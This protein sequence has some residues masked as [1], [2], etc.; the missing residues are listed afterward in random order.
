MHPYYINN[1][2]TNPNKVVFWW[3][4]KCGCIFVRKL[5]HY[6]LHSNEET[7]DI[8][9]NNL[10]DYNHILF[11]RNPYKRVVSGYI[12]CYATTHQQVVIFNNDLS[13]KDTINELI[14]N[15]FKN[16]DKLHFDYQISIKDVSDPNCNLNINKIFDIESIDYTFLSKLFLD[17]F[18]DNDILTALRQSNHHVDYLDDFKENVSDYHVTDFDELSGYPRYQYF[19]TNELIEKVQSFYDCDFIF[20]EMNGIKY[21]PPKVNI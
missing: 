1:P 13:F 17:M 11:V 12:D 9:V 15:E 10:N 14:E 19:Y 21:D 3:T 4:P 2:V 5:Y 18:V 20:L 6:F 8:D 7:E 16:I